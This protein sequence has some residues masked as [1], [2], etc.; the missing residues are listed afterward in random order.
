MLVAW[1]TL[2]I[3]LL[4]VISNI[5]ISLIKKKNNVVFT[6]NVYDYFAS[7]IMTHIVKKNYT[8]KFIKYQHNKFLFE[9]V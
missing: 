8:S 4:T 1:E 6:S 3:F 7:K 2:N 9:R 5:N